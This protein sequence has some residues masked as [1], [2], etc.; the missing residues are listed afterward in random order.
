MNS[1]QSILTNTYGPFTHLYV[2]SETGIQELAVVPGQLHQALAM[3][4]L[5]L[6]CG[7]A[8]KHRTIL[9]GS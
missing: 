9:L 4:L 3:V 1:T 5:P 8:A 7:T 6:L 2:R